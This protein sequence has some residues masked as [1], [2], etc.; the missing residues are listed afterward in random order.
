[1][2]KQEQE[3][4]FEEAFRRLEKTVETLEAGGLTLDKAVALFEEGMRLAKLCTE[5]L[6]AAELKVTQLQNAF[7]EQMRGLEE[8][9]R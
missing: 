7:A 4:S 1:M 8:R 5:R 2:P 3:L 6:D 9:H